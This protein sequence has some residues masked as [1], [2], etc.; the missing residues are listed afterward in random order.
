MRGTMEHDYL[1]VGTSV[2]Q[3]IALRWTE[4]PA[5][6]VD[7]RNVPQNG[8]SLNDCRGLCCL[9]SIIVDVIS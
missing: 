6:G 9:S 5:A 4:T 7:E 8:P 1:R 3:G 2:C